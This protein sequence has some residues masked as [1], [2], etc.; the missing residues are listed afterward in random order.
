MMEALDN[1]RRL[2]ATTLASFAALAAFLGSGFE[3]DA[4]TLGRQIAGR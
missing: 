4:R 1:P 2:R 3:R